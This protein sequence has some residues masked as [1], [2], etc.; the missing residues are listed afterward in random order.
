MAYRWRPSVWLTEGFAYPEAMVGIDPRARWIGRFF[1]LG[2]LV[3]LGFPI[4]GV[5]QGRPEYNNGTATIASVLLFGVFYA[6]FWLWVLDR[7]SRAGFFI[8][9]GGMV[10]I[11]AAAL[12]GAPAAWNGIVY[13]LIYVSVAVAVWSIDWRVGLASCIL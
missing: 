7:R 1:A 11:I 9:V 4:V 6:A 13:M 5:L 12:G 10:A 8:T 2:W 3:M